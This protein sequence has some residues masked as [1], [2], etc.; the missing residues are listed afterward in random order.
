MALAAETD[1]YLAAAVSG[2]PLVAAELRRA[3]TDAVERRRDAGARVETHP[4]GFFRLPLTVSDRRPPGFY[5][6]LWRDAGLDMP[7]PDEG[8]H[9]HIFDLRSRILI[10]RLRDVAY[11][12]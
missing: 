12:V 2:T 3:L 1:A 7:R 10:G 6:H 9:C 4:L 11:D 5:L 8:I